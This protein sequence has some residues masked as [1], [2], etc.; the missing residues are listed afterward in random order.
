MICQE[1]RGRNHPDCLS[2]DCACGHHGSNV[3]SLTDEERQQ[4]RNGTLTAHVMP[5]LPEENTHA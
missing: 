2:G 5:R 4:V 1:C 3:R